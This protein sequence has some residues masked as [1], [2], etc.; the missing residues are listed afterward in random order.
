MAQIAEGIH[1]L[2]TELVNYYLVEEGG[3]CTLVDAALPRYHDGL[4]R[5]LQEL[6]LSLDALDAV[7]LTHAHVDHI[8]M[9]ERL[10]TEAGATVY[11]H[12]ADADMARTAKQPKRDASFLPY[13]VKPT[14]L[15]LMAH[16]VANGGGRPT[17]VA[18][19]STYSD[20]DVLD[21]P[22]RPRVVATPGHTD[23]HCSLHFEQHGVLITGDAMCSRNPLTGREGPQVMP[24]AFNTSTSRALESLDRLAALDAPHICFGHGDPSDQGARA[25]VERARELGPS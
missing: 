23:G 15:K 5:A 8:G 21:V 1:R 9:A 11:V 6:G 24:S 7:V 18:E 12:S 20:G 16:I 14:A 10:R 25:A 13:L 19:V 2:G 17:K 3:R 4:I 22:G